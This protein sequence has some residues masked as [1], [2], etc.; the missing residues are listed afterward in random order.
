MIRHCTTGLPTGMLL[1]DDFS[2]VGR[3]LPEDG[4]G[5]AR[6]RVATGE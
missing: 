6:S 2:R 1:R 4:R 3:Q 5:A